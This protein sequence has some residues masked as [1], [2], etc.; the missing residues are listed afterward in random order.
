M[1][2]RKAFLVLVTLAS[3]V[4]IPC[5]GIGY[6]KDEAMMDA[7]SYLASTDY[8]QDSIEDVDIKEMEE[9]A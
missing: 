4:V 5:S 6:D 9:Q 2:T 7:C 1:K 8:P 3:G